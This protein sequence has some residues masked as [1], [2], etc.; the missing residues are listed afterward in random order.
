M[1]DVL[2]FGS[3]LKSSEDI[4]LLLD[5][6][7]GVIRNSRS[8]AL[9]PR[10]MAGSPQLVGPNFEHA[11]FVFD[12]VVLVSLPLSTKTASSFVL[13]TCE[14]VE[15]FFKD[16]YPLRGCITIDDVYINDNPHII[17][18]RRFKELVTRTNDQNW[19]GCIVLPA[20]EDVLERELFGVSPASFAQSSP[21]VRY[22]VPWKPTTSNVDLDYEYLALNWVSMLSKSELENGL[23][24]LLGD[25]AKHA[26]TLSFVEHV[27][28]LPSDAQALTQEFLP[29]S[30]VKVM[31]SRTQI[32]LQFNDELGL[33]IQ[34]G[35]SYQFAAFEK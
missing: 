8:N 24:K 29:A 35:C 13:S 22:R 23:L 17:V 18:G 30:H 28:S 4:C 19:S 9:T 3:A 7:C 11:H 26:G 15:A 12:S 5:K 20:A 6:Y 33:P 32:R 10:S 1:L 27:T 21:L 31:K 2:G 16:G 34:P 25:S 14:L